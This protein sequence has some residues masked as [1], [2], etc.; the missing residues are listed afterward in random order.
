MEEKVH[1][2]EQN[3]DDE[4]IESLASDSKIR[5]LHDHEQYE[6]ESGRA[7]KAVDERHGSGQ[8][9]PHEM[10]N[11]EKNSGD[12]RRGERTQGCYQHFDALPLGWS[13]ARW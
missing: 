6:R 12:C 3:G 5:M 7:T 11:C 8:V 4:E 10:S 1:G 13:Y 2:A 9:L